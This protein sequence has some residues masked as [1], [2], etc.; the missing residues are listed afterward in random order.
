MKR[1]DIDRKTILSFIKEDQ[2]KGGVAE[3]EKEKKAMKDEKEYRGIC[4][5]CINFRFCTYRKDFGPPIL[6]C[7]EFEGYKPRVSAQK[8]STPPE[9][10]I[11]SKPEEKDYSKYKGLCVNCD[12]R[13]TC[14]YPKTEGG[15]WHCEEY[16]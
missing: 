4:V 14:T 3:I 5:C 11:K 7:D 15:V 1:A 9:S 6:Y 2:R 13:E 10:Q 8:I 12:N 16:Q